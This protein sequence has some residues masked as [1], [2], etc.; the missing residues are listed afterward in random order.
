MFSAWKAVLGAAFG[1]ALAPL[2]ARADEIKLLFATLTPP[3]YT[4]NTRVYA[5]WVEQLNA[6]G[7]GILQ[8]DIRN[9]TAIANNGNV[10]D[11]V[12]N[13]VMQIAVGIPGLV[14]GKFPLTEVVGLPF[15]AED[16]E[17]SS[18]AYW[19]LYK[20]GL[21]DAE[22]RDIKPLALS[23]YL[24]QGVHLAKAPTS[25]DDLKGIRLRVVTKLSGD[26]IGHLNGTPM[27]IEPADT[28]SA[29]QRGT[30]DGVVMSW[31]GLGQLNLLEVTSYHIET[32]LGTG[33]TM[34]FMS[35]K[36]YDSLPQAAK[37]LLDDNAGES[38]SRAYGHNFDQESRE[39]R[40]PIDASSKH[41]VAHLSPVQ[42]AHWRAS[43]EPV[44]DNWTGSH[45]GGA[46]LLETYRALL[47]DVKAG[48]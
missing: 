3:D 44:I 2:V 38:F 32:P 23:M 34:V 40:A 14:G 31:A 37:K 9:G 7:R 30:V 17:S 4:S 28:F 35:R 18:V 13:D 1:I 22:Y 16:A 19:R 8:I 6:I 20:T 24:P 45:P 27:V 46:K 41:I 25:I 43:I 33:A 12:D 10:Y 26:V 21:L 39:Q 42:D 47:A 48:R 15:V 5:P 36:K 11:R 29:V